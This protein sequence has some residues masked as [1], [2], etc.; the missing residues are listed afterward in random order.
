MTS[1]AITVR[2]VYGQS[3]VMTKAQVI[4]CVSGRLIMRAI[5]GVHDFGKR[6]FPIGF[7]FIIQVTQYGQQGAVKAFHLTVPMWVVRG[8]ARTLDATLFLELSK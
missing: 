7:G 2:D 4:R 8:G 1:T 3:R 5:V 6:T